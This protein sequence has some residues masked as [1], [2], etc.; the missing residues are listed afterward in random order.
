[1]KCDAHAILGQLR[2]LMLFL[3]DGFEGKVYLDSAEVIDVQQG[4]GY[5]FA[6][7]TWLDSAA[8]R[9]STAICSSE[10][11]QVQEPQDLPVVV[12]HEL[13]VAAR[14]DLERKLA[15]VRNALGGAG[16]LPGYAFEIL[17]TAYSLD[18]L[19]ADIF[20]QAFPHRLTA[21]RHQLPVIAAAASRCVR[22]R[23]FA[24][25]NAA[26]HTLAK[27][28][29]SALVRDINRRFVISTVLVWGRLQSCA[30]RR[31]YVTPIPC[32]ILFL[33]HFSQVF[34]YGR[35]QRHH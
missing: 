33:K 24:S 4:M 3:P 30:L 26:R 25:A 34:F 12:K 16:S 32:Y 22:S 9:R 10:G 19:A 35:R 21:H 8:N 5:T 1:M 29:S 28:I 15:A 7:E 18:G 31:Q 17:Y 14:G 23:W 13:R 6:F 20:T 2:Q 11:R 27:F